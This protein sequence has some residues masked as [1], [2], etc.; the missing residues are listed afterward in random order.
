VL[1]AVTSDP[2]AA[3][4]LIAGQQRLTAAE[5][6]YA[7]TALS[8]A[9]SGP[10]HHQALGRWHD[11][12]RAASRSSGAVISAVNANTIALGGMHDAKALAYDQATKENLALVT[13]VGAAAVTH[14]IPL[15]DFAAIGYSKTTASLINSV[16]TAH[17]TNYEGKQRQTADLAVENLRQNLTDQ[18]LTSL[19]QHHLYDR[20]LHYDTVSPYPLQAEERAFLDAKG[21]IVKP[22]VPGSKEHRAYVSWITANLPPDIEDDI[23]LIYRPTS[24]TDAVAQAKNLGAP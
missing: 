17:P 21:H 15:G 6:D 4:Y 11:T 2:T 7:A 19:F 13:T 14:F 16:I 20:G 10:D 9:G 1:I 18:V 12:I 3:G 24:E 23:L 8:Q 22:M 5:L